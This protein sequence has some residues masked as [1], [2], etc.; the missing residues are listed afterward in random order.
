MR[1]RLRIVVP[2]LALVLAVVLLAGCDNTGQTGGEGQQ[3]GQQS[4]EE[5]QSMQL[6]T[7]EQWARS[8]HARPVTFAAEEEGC[9]N[10]HDGLTFSETGG[11]FQPR[12]EPEEATGSAEATGTEEEPQERDW[13]VATDCRACHM[14]RGAEIADAG[15]VGGVPNLDEVQAGLG[16]LCI[17]CHNG[18]HPPGEQDGELRAPH[19]SVQA[20]M[21]YGVNTLPVEGAESTGTASEEASQSPHAK[22]DDTCVGCHV[23]AP[24]EEDGPN[25]TFA[26]TSYEG[27]QQEGCHEED[28]T[29][30]GTAQEDYDGDGQT[31][32]VQAEV[33]GL[34]E[35]LQDA[36]N[37]AAGSS[38][39]QSEGGQVVFTGGG[40][41]SGDDPVYHAAYNYFFVVDDSS[42]GIHNTQFTVQLLQDSISAV[43]E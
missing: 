22:V 21:L 35:N 5:T 1:E 31:E 43:S 14:A 40:N 33:E 39:F 9:K 37:R 20:D 26:I 32:S 41:R 7:V 17:A 8:T 11:G 29:E 10:C 4:E 38:E 15:S 36:V 16:S 2:G 24:S 12:F 30:G 13:V 34:L 42:M 19:S 28:M 23:N 18:W 27:C 25:H 3:N 6:G